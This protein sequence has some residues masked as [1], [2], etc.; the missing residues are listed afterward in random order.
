MKN[1]GYSLN[2]KNNLKEIFYDI[3]TIRK[4]LS[5]I[6]GVP[7]KKINEIISDTNKE[8]DTKIF[9]IN[10]NSKNFVPLKLN[11]NNNNYSNCLEIP[12]EINLNQS[13]N[14]ENYNSYDS[15]N[16]NHSNF[17]NNFNRNFINENINSQQSLSSIISN[18]KK[19]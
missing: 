5:Q 9:S 13:G 2:N 17:Y 8:F 7:R 16:K 12:I 14:S 19:N 1:N 4:E 3:K 10:E 11:K 18:L 15:N 6:K